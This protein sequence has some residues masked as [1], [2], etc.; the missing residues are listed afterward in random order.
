MAAEAG[1]AAAESGAAETSAAG[2]QTLRRPPRRRPAAAGGRDPVITR[3]ARSAPS[4]AAARAAGSTLS[5]TA[6]GQAR[7]RMQNRGSRARQR[8]VVKTGSGGTR[9]QNVVLL[10]FVLAVLLVAAT[11]FA[12]KNRPGLSPYAGTDMLQLVAITVLYFL[13]ALLAGASGKTARLSAWFGGLILITVG[14]GEAA[15]LAKALDVF[16]L[17][18]KT[19]STD[20]QPPS[21][22]GGGGGTERP[23]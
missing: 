9:Y 23:Q 16:G 6:P 8:P 12:R 2:A 11:P 3:A 5:R 21:G 20:G 1:T 10:E 15:A 17:A 22:G 18:T 13:L 4:G 7:S 14:L 19:G